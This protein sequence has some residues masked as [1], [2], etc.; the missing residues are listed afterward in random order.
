M[1]LLKHGLTLT[2]VQMLV[3]QKPL[4]SSTS[5]ANRARF[6]TFRFAVAGG[7]SPAFLILLGLDIELPGTERRMVRLHLKK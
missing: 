2:V 6:P 3:T 7:I 1:I 5:G 4:D